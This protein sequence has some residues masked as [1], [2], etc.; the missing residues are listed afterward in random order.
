M[1]RVKRLQ[2]L[3]WDVGAV[4]LPEIKS[5]VSAQ[6]DSFFRKYNQLINQYNKDVGIDLASVSPAP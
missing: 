1:D 2:R 5:N 3:R 6:E 4:L